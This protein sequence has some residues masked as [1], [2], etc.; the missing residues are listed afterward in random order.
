[1]TPYIY[2]PMKHNTH[3]CDNIDVTCYY[4]TE[5]HEI[6][7]TSYWKICATAQNRSQNPR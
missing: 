7:A 4:V 1:M 6:I 5:V 3:I 2:A